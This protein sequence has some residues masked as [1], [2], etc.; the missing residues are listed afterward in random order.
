[1]LRRLSFVFAFALALASFGSVGV[2]NANGALNFTLVNATG[3]T[4]YKVQMS[5]S[6]VNSWEEDM[7][8]S[9]VMPSGTSRDITFSGYRPEVRLW[10]LKVTDGQ[11]T[12]IEWRGIDLTAIT[13]LTL[14]IVDGQAIAEPVSILN[15]TL[16]NQTGGTIYKLQMSPSDVNN[17]EEDMLGS[18]VM[19]N[20]TSRYL[21]FNGYRSNVRR[22]DLKA[23]DPAG[24]SIEWRGLDLS[25]F[26]TLT[27]RI[28]DG[29]PMAYPE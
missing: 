12:S 13:Q 5:P 22:W 7:L 2:A 15:F 17:W 28:I 9:E 21:R 6:E 11:G 18:E 1:M 29:T 27:L 23:T 24:T 26:S 20:G 10:D 19:E 25:S 14:R 4:I 3:V 8:G 16:V